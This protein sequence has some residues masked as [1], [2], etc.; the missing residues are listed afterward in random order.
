M[1]VNPTNKTI[2]DRMIRISFFEFKVQNIFDVFH[3]ARS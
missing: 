3:S 2:T 1:S